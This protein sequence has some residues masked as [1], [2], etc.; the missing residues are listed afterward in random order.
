M[1]Q[2]RAACA[3]RCFIVPRRLGKL[4]K[5]FR[6]VHRYARVHAYTGLLPF[7]AVAAAVAAA[8]AAAAVAVVGF[9]RRTAAVG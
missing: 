5:R 4:A 9:W 6:I 2:M 8:A 1:P 7:A 3:S